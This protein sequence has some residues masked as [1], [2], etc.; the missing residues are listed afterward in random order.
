MVALDR[1]PSIPGRAP[2]VR[3]VSIGP[4]AMAFTWMPFGAASQ[5]SARVKPMI[6]ALAVQ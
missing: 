5:A 1:S 6:A 2:R 4:G 3:S